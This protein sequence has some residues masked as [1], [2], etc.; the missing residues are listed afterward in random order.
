MLARRST[1]HSTIRRTIIAVTL[2]LST[3]ALGKVTQPVAASPMHMGWSSF[4]T[5][6]WEPE[7]PWPPEEAEVLG[8]SLVQGWIAKGTKHQTP[9]YVYNS[10]VD[11]P[12]VAII[13]GVHGNEKAGWKAALEAKEITVKRGRLLIIP[14][15]NRPAVK[16]GKRTSSLG[17]LNRSFPRTKS[18][19]PDNYL[20]RSIWNLMLKYRPDWLVDL[21]E[22]YSYHLINKKSVG[23]TVIYYPVAKAAPAAKAMAKAASALVSN[24]KHAFSVLKYPVAGS[25]ARAV[26]IR[27]GTKGMI[28][29]TCN[30]QSLSLRKKEHLAAVNALLKHLRMQ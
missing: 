19:S 18:D 14:E 1:H 2:L 10:G 6:N 29:E 12:T 22:G 17:D 23:Q 20:A 11:G 4:S 15:A 13:G 21:H 24:P 5:G 3:M 26:S 9:Y 28:V 30:K 8:A 16:A 7:I 25:L 27:L